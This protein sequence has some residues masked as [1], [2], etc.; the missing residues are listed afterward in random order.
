[1]RVKAT[2]AG[3][4]GHWRNVGDEFEVTAKQFSKN[5]MAKVSEPKAAPAPD[6]EP[7]EPED[8][9]AEVEAEDKSE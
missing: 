5:W 8:D 2:K 3:V 7:S 6:P 4:F 1:M 9:A